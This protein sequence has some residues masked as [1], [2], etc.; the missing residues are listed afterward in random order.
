MNNIAVLLTVFNRREK[1]LKCLKSLV[2]CSLPE[3]HAIDI[4]LVDDGSSDGTHEAVAEQFPQVNIIRGT[5]NLFWNRGMHLAWKTAADRLEYDFYLWLNDDTIIHQDTVQE[6][7]ACSE[8]EQHRSIICGSTCAV[9]DPDEITYGG[10]RPENNILKPNGQKQCCD[11]VNGN[12]LL[13]PKYVYSKVGTNDPVFHH[14]MGDFDYGA[15][16][17]KLG[18]HLI[19]APKVL[20]VCDE[21]PTLDA[22]CN[23]ETPILKRLKLLYTPLGN[24][25]IQHFIFE[26]RHRGLWKSC[27]HFVTI[28]LRA[29]FPSFWK[30]RK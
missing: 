28:H 9:N 19:V 7:I 1:T 25:P 4:Y 2:D 22:W 16:A 5:G 17:R 18:I 23:P 29:I 10:W 15:R 20:G 21:H 13:V 11:Y 14:A 26:R 6:L 24:H 3:N 27:F 30:N 8:S 12:I